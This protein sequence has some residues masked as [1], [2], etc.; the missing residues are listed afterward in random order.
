MV[1]S[2][3]GNHVALL[4]GTQTD[5]ASGAD[6]IDNSG[7]LDTR[8]TAISGNSG[9]AIAATEGAVAVST[10]SNAKANATSIDGG[11]ADDTVH[12]DGALTTQATANADAVGIAFTTKGEAGADGAADGKVSSEATALGIDS[13]GHDSNTRKT[14]AIDFT[15]GILTLTQEE[16]R[17]S[18]Q[19]ADT[20]TNGADLVVGAT[21]VTVTLAG[22]GVQSEGAASVEANASATGYAA[23]IDSGALDDVVTNTGSLDVTTTANADTVAIGYSA[24]TGK[25]GRGKVDGS[26]SAAA[27]AAGI[28]SDG[29][30]QATDKTRSVQVTAGGLTYADETI[31]QR[32]NGN[33]VVSNSGDIAARATAVSV[34]AD[35]GVVTTKGA[36]SVKSQSSATSSVAAIDSGSGDD[37]ITITAG[38][39]GATATSVAVAV[40][41]DVS[42]EGSAGASSGLWEAGVKADAGAV[43]IAADGNASAQETSNELRID[44]T[45]PGVTYTRVTASDG[46][47]GAGRDYVDNAAAINVNSTAVTPSIAVAATAK[48]SATARTT[49]DADARAVAIDSGSEDDVVING[50]HLVANALA[51]PDVVNVAVTQAGTAITAD[52]VWQG[53]ASA[54]AVALG[55]DADGGQSKRNTLTASVDGSGAALGYNKTVQAG[56]GDDSVTNHGDIDATATSVVPSVNAAVTS[57]GLAATI[58]RSEAKADAGAIHGGDGVDQLANTATLTARARSTAVAV[59]MSMTPNGAAIAGAPV[60]DSGV[61]AQAHS[62]GIGGDG[63]VSYSSKDWSLTLRNGAVTLAYDNNIQQ[64]SGNDVIDNSGDINSFATAVTPSVTV[65]VAAKGFAAAVSNAE[66]SADASSIRGGGGDDT[67]TNRGHLTAQAVANADSVDATLSNAGLSLSFNPIWDGGTTSTATATGIAGD[68]GARSEHSVR[69]VSASA[70]GVEIVS[71]KQQTLAQGNDTIENFGVVDVIATAVPVALGLGSTVDGVAV[72]DVTAKAQARASAIDAGGGDDTVRNHNLLNVTANAVAVAVNGAFSASGVSLAG[73]SS[74]NGGVNAEALAFGIEGDGAGTSRD[75]QRSLKITGL[76]PQV[77]NDDDTSLATGEDNISNDSKIHVIATAVSPGLTVGAS[78]TAGAAATVATANAKAG[79]TAIGAGAGEDVVDNSGHL[80][81]TADATAVSVGGTYSTAGLAVSSD[82]AWNGGTTADADALGIDGGSGDDTLT[83]DNVVEAQAVSVTPS[84]QVGIAVAGVGVALADATAKS[85]ATAIEGGDGNDDITNLRQLHARS[86]ATAQALSVS[87]TGGGVVLAGDALWDGGVIA[88]ASATGIGGDADQPHVN[89][90]PVVLLESDATALVRQQSIRVS[91]GNDVIDNQGNIDIV[92]TAVSPSVS[93]AVAV[94]GVSGA[95]STAT[96]KSHAVAIDAGAG[97]DRIDNSAKLTLQATANADAVNVSVAPGGLAITSDAVWNGGTTASADAVGIAADGNGENVTIR[98]GLRRNNSTG[99]V[100]V[101]NERET[102]AVG[103]NDVVTNLGDIDAGAV[104]VAPSLGVAVA[105]YGVSVALTDA[106]ANAAATGIDLGIGDDRAKNFAH[107]QTHATANADSLGVSV[108]VFGVGAASNAV[109]SGGTHSRADAFGIVGGDGDDDIQNGSDVIPSN[110][111]VDVSSTAVTVAGNVPFTF[112]GVA[113]ATTTATAQANAGMFRGDGGSDTIFNYNDSSANADATAVAVTGSIGVFGVAL[114]SDSVWN[115]GTHADAHAFGL[116]GG[117]GVDTLINSALLDARTRARAN[118]DQI[119]VTLIGVAGS[120]ATSK[121]LAE[122]KVMTGDAGDDSIANHGAIKAVAD[123]R[124]TSVAVDI[125]GLGAAIASDA[126]WDGGTGADANAYGIS[127]GDGND[128]LHNTATGV[129]ELGLTEVDDGEDAP[130]RA[131]TDSVGIAA[132]L[133]ILAEANSA[134]TATTHASVIDGGNGNDLLSNRGVLKVHTLA[135]AGGVSVTGLG[136]GASI[137]GSFLDAVTKA[138]ANGVGMD[139]GAGADA[140]VAHLTS[141]IDINAKAVTKNTAVGLALGGFASADA[142]TLS[143]S[144]AT[145]VQGGDG[146]DSIQHDGTLA[147]SAEA[148]TVA[149]NVTFSGIGAATPD[150]RSAA[151]AYAYGIDAGGGDTSL[152]GAM[153]NTG[154]VTA[155]ASATATGQ[156]IGIAITGAAL[157]DAH[158]EADVGAVGLAGG[159]NGDAIVNSGAVSVTGTAD[160]TARSIGFAA[161]GY[162]VSRADATADAVSRG[163]QGGA[164][165]DTLNNTA[166]GSYD[167][168]ATATAHARGVST[169]IIGAARAAATTTPTA[170]AVGLDGGDGDDTVDNQGVVG[171]MANAN[172]DLSN[173][174]WTIAGANV[175]SIG[176]TTAAHATGIDGGAG[177]DSG[178]NAGTLNVDAVADFQSTGSA[179]SLAGKSAGEGNGVLQVTGTAIGAAG[180]AGDDT[181]R[182]L[183]PMIV[184]GDATLTLNGGSRAIFGGANSGVSVSANGYA[185]G[186]DGG[187]DQD[188]LENA[189]D[190]QVTAQVDFHATQTAFAFIGSGTTGGTLTA[191]ARA[192]GFNGGSGNDQLR[193][194]GNLT[195]AAIAGIDANGRVESKVGGGSAEST[196]FSLAEAGG[197]DAGAGDDVFTNT[198]VFAV[199]ASAAPTAA[200]MS[201]AGGVF[202]DGITRANVTAGTRTIAVDGGAGNN[203]LLN[204]LGAELQLSNAGTASA[205]ANSDGNDL[206]HFAGINIDTRATATVTLDVVSARGLLGGDGNNQL[207]NDG[208]LRIVVNPTAASNARADGDALINGAGT[209]VAVAHADA[210]QA[211]G[212][213]SGNGANTVI[214]NGAFVV[215]LAPHAT[216]TAYSDADGIDFFTAPASRA[217]IATSADDAHASGIASGDGNNFIANHGSM[218]IRAAPRSTSDHAFADYGGDIIAIDSFATAVATANNAAATG[219]AAGDGNN[220]IWNTGDIDVTAQPYAGAVAIAKGRG[221]DG[222]ATAHA[223]A[224]A[225][226]ASAAGI[227]TGDGDNTIVND[228]TLNVHTAPA[229]ASSAT[230]TPGTGQYEVTGTTTITRY[231]WINFLFTKIVEVVTNVVDVVVD[232]GE[233]DRLSVHTASNARAYGILTGNGDDIITN[234]GALSATVSLANVTSAD[235]AIASGAG[236]DQVTLGDGSSTVGRVELGEGDDS[237]TLIAS[238]QLHEFGGAAGRADGGGGSDTLVLDGNGAYAGTILNFEHAAKRSAG[239]YT[240]ASLPHMSEVRVQRGTL[241]L[242]SAYGFAPGDSL[243]ANVYADGDHGQLRVNGQVDLDGKLQVIEGGG[244]YTDGTTYDVLAADPTHTLQGNFAEVQMP[245]AMPLLGFSYIQSPQKGQVRADV[246]PFAAAATGAVGSAVAGQLDGLSGNADGDLVTLLGEIQHLGAGEHERAYASLSPDSYASFSQAAGNTSVALLGVMQQRMSGQRSVAPSTAARSTPPVLLAYNGP[247]FSDLFASEDEPVDRRFGLWLSAFGQHGEQ[248]ADAGYSGFDYDSAGIVLGFDGGFGEG[249]VLGL[250]LGYTRNDLTLGGDR[251]SGDIASTLLSVYGSHGTANGYVDATLAYGRN[252]YDNDRNVAVGNIRRTAK[253]SHE[254]TTL[255]ASL[256]AGYYLP[257]GAWTLEPNVSLQYAHLKD[258]AFQESGAGAANMQV[259]A[260]SNNSF[261]STAGVRASRSYQR[262]NGTLSLQLGAAW[263]HDFSNNRVV[264]AAFAG[265]P[266]STFAVPAQQ[267][268][269]NGALL[270]A[271]IAFQTQHGWTTSLRYQG[272]FRSGFQSH[273]IAGQLRYEFD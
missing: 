209:G 55:I 9:A 154:T 12:N 211:Q 224:H 205:I 67:V 129:I 103:G 72:T 36:G 188:T 249:N 164:G 37:S 75:V 262:R 76:S 102:E 82:A 58:S 204:A 219:I 31:V 94:A 251:G 40:Q 110:A 119:A 182:N 214:N 106:T 183:G 91:S 243:V 29:N 122:T 153:S 158:T 195:T 73:N 253:S 151:Q 11:D 24:A 200:S 232:D 159:A 127:G 130:V 25:S 170:T 201:N 46:L 78:L 184:N 10:P 26:A 131:D 62:V 30:A 147:A 174:T 207:Q 198:G 48:G 192:L 1:P 59:G 109:W 202:G 191:N 6:T 220:F 20:V 57:K 140:I 113:A 32:A 238:A 247:L 33:D 248:D 246:Q 172:T 47:A 168:H 85:H 141:N 101:V 81:A 111:A 161:F 244:F 88:E 123:A 229:S 186:L 35:G 18:G 13:D 100:T 257:H 239:T 197:A 77:I 56:S 190:L 189:A 51:Q 115:G 16:H 86:V 193:N 145:G 267:V 261:V 150:A 162:S 235:T 50:A 43:G 23:G 245:D 108:N 212:V 167:V 28:I 65:A 54:D 240:L 227:G 68:G 143:I 45:N 118:S 8:A 117:D 89:S 260:R 93:V 134:S 144:H 241:Q 66:A 142:A 4:F 252:D 273:A 266:N 133:G 160:V 61:S 92:A 95:L 187:S 155:N 196:V 272:E 236:N 199:S 165:N 215:E 98:Q 210:A 63:G 242:D 2:L 178:T 269:R 223:T 194:F 156:S 254:G 128:I 265:A 79:A 137:S 233:V 181:L 97:D 70:A 38:T 171:V 116:E 7:S 114:A 221:F 185:T 180:A 5:A 83:N 42:K 230:A 135:D 271:G 152:V 52:A 39:L 84:A 17:Y 234:N 60:W 15:P 149:R 126:F 148:E 179:W 177:N 132:T 90:G 49:A 44:F 69:S 259:D 217:N 263:L 64:A 125:S 250:S 53:G 104:A 256:R 157:G 268:E 203:V 27:I 208:S 138:D 237:L 124:A 21:A 139:G 87:V 166:S 80:I 41:A 14:R 231:E 264:R 173:T 112:G 176:A 206:S 107:I 19:G 226:N 105:V 218:S 213:A 22:A 175:Q 74:W 216:A 255:A 228:G 222:D 120:I 225:D 258:D 146:Y 136:I 163:A 96:A 71:S 270:D 34:T 3:S 99:E 121:S 169:N